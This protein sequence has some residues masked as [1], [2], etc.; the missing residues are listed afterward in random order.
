MFVLFESGTSVPWNAV[1]HLGDSVLLI[2]LTLAMVSVDLAVSRRTTLSLG[3]LRPVVIASALTV[4]TKLAFSAFGVGGALDFSGLSGHAMLSAILYPIIAFRTTR[5][6]SRMRRWLAAVAAGVVVTTVAASRVVLG[7]HSM[8]DVLSGLVVGVVAAAV[9]IR[10]LSRA[11]PDHVGGS[12]MTLS[13]VVLLTTMA[14]LS[15]ALPEDLIT[16]MA[17]RM[18]DGK[19]VHRRSDLRP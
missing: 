14:I 8:I 2:P 3:W 12:E 4:V 11:P 7:V 16:D 6:S 15:H 9:A 5:R 19:P 13:I 10:T 17:A 1:T 18:I